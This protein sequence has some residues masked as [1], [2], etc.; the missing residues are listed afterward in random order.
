M[1]SEASPASGGEALRAAMRF[2]ARPAEAVG[3]ALSPARG[4]TR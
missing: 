2:A 3:A 4:R 1:V